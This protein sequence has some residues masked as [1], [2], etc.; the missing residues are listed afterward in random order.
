[1]PQP[2]LQSVHINRPLI[3][4]STAY[5]QDDANFVF[6]KVFPILPVD[7][8][9]DLYF[10]YEKDAL[11]RDEAQLRAPGTESAGTGYGLTTASYN[12][13]VWAIHDDVPDQIIENSDAPLQPLADS[14]I[15]VTQ[16][17]L[18]RQENLW[19]GSFFKSGVWGTD[20]TPS[21]LW[22]DFAA[23]DPVADVKTGIQTILQNT[24]RYPNRLTMGFPVFNILT[25]HP[26]IVDRIKYGASNGNPAVVS[27][28][29]LAQ[30]FG[31]ERVLVA[32]AVQATANENNA[33]QTYAFILGKNALLSYAPPGP[34]LRTPS[35]GYCFYWRGISG[36]IG[37]PVKITDFYMPWLKSTRVEGE[38]A[39][40]MHVVSNDCGYMINGAVA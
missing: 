5:I 24:G 32:R 2:Q 16:K 9:S 30:V 40:D 17:L 23:S 8:Q 3:N 29:A 34:A 37:L 20:F 36:G 19:V 7:K 25:N 22:S 14:T 13:Q 38:V 39:V 12:A 1:M 33:T 21:A 27:E 31:V 4:I 11:L 18:L 35:A 15:M 10:Q 26:D 6:N 28:Q